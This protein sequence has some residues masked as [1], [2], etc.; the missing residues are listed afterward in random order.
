MTGQRVG[1]VRVS[2][3]DQNLDRQL[4]NEK[5]DRLFS[6][7]ASGKDIQRPQ[8]KEL[9]KFVREGDSVI[10]HSMDRLARNLDDLRKI[11]KELTSRD[12]SIKFIKENLTFDNQVSPMS[13]LLLSVMGAFAEFERS[14]IK[15]RQREGIELA[16]KRGVYK[17]RRSSLSE[18]QMQ[19]IID[20]LDSG[21]AKTSIAKSLGISRETLY[22]HLRKRDERLDNT[23]KE[24]A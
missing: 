15:E 4:E 11:V 12:V 13:N 8:L 3:F 1:Y 10:V 16:K 18:N 5:I 19:T 17:G 6:E 9:L 20:R 21:E 22:Q 7:K 2:S 14:L 23:Q 24:S